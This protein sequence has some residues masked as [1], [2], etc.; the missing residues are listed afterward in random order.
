MLC[1]KKGRRIWESVRGCWRPPTAR[2]DCRNDSRIV[3]SFIGCFMSKKE[4][5]E[6][7]KDKKGKSTHK[8]ERDQWEV[9]KWR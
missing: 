3:G 1:W 6:K 2:D 4:K 5:D 7:G 8:S 9:P